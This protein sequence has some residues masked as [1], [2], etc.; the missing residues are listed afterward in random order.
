[1]LLVHKKRINT[2]EKTHMPVNSND[3]YHLREG[4]AQTENKQMQVYHVFLFHDFEDSSIY[5]LPSIDNCLCA[6]L[7][8]R[9]SKNPD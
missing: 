6:N 3:G 9:S 8:P 1:M 7:L 5:E 4:T 2:F